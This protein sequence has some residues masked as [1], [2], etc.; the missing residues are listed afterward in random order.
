MKQTAAEQELKV[1]LWR[2]RERIWR[3]EAVE[4]SVQNQCKA[5]TLGNSGQKGAED[6]WARRS[7]IDIT[8]EEQQ[9]TEMEEVPPRP[10]MGYP[11][12]LEPLRSC[13]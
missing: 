1:P 2:A 9:G 13:L 11:G 5:V 4:C 8:A 3:K 10:G 12:K 6:K 7:R